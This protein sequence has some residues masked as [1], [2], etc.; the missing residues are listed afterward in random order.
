MQVELQVEVQGEVRVEVQVESQAEV[1]V[2]LQ[3]EVQG[4]VHVELQVEVR[5]GPLRPPPQ[6][7]LSAF[8]L[9]LS[10]FLNFR[11]VR[12]DFSNLKSFW[13]INPIFGTVC[14]HVFHSINDIERLLFPNT[15]YFC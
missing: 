15:F 4:E 12:T 8:R 9:V 1:Q 5:K 10:V 6:S 14:S 3:V 13:N 2:E 7:S 11:I